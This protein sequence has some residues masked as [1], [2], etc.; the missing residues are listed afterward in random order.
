M[1]GNALKEFRIN[2]V[3]PNAHDHLF[4][5]KLVFIIYISGYNLHQSHLDLRT[6]LHCSK[7]RT[8]AGWQWPCWHHNSHGIT[9]TLGHPHVL[10]EC[11]TGTTTILRMAA[12]SFISANMSQ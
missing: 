5:N 10:G 1:T 3:N 2:Y 11:L 7:N 6:T 12:V 4:E 8:G 9:G